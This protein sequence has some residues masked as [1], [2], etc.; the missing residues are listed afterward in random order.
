M[1]EVCEEATD[2]QDGGENLKS[3]YEAVLKYIDMRG[4]HILR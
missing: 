3:R 1:V 2:V 4:R